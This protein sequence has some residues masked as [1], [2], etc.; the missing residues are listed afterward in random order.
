MGVAMSTLS[1]ADGGG[2]GG[3][4]EMD[5]SAAQAEPKV[6]ALPLNEGRRFDFAIQEGVGESLNEYISGAFWVLWGWINV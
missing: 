1:T 5:D 4:A 2:A 3:E 6:E